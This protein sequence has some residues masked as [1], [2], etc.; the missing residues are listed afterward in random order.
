MTDLKVTIK[1]APEI[2]TVATRV[3]SDPADAAA[4]DPLWEAARDRVTAYAADRGL[5]ATG[6]LMG[7]FY[8]D[9]AD[10]DCGCDFA[11]ALPT[12]GPVGEEGAV[13]ALTLPAVETMA[14]TLCPASIAAD[15]AD[16]LYAAFLVW[17][18]VHGY[19]IDGPYR[20]L[21]HPAGEGRY[22]SEPLIEIQFPVVGLG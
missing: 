18:D 13:R 17:I 6:P 12:S 15:E 16:E 20:E 19:R 8:E 4:F 7:V 21:F 2:R 14:T 11:V 1:S 9:P 22:A 3:T 10:P 5:A